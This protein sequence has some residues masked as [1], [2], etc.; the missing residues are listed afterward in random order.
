M[1]YRC[2]ASPTFFACSLPKITVLKLSN[3]LSARY[4]VIFYTKS[5]NHRLVIG[6]LSIT[7]PSC[8]DCNIDVQQMVLALFYISIAQIINLRFD[9][10]EG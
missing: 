9:F 3:L 6:T 5:P 8:Y 7:T 4:A 2:A 1:P 10:V